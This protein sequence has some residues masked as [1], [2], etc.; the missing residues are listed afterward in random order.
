MKQFDKIVFNIFNNDKAKKAGALFEKEM[1]MIQAQ[2]S[3]YR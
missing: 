3:D 1:Q 2:F